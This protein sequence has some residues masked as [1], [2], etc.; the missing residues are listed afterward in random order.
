VRAELHVDGPAAVI[1]L[2]GELDTASATDVM[3]LVGS[4]LRS[5]GVT[6]LTID[7][8]ALMYI[9]SS[10]LNALLFAGKACEQ[11]GA[12]LTLA[13]PIDRVRRILTI[14]GVDEFFVIRP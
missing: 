10:G 1:R 7:L 14:T 12:T 3:E 6:D 8:A 13:N 4:A 2:D 11:H 9:D 5:T